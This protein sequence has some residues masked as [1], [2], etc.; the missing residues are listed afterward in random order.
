MSPANPHLHAP[1]G[2]FGASARDASLAV[3]L[4][5][6]RGQSPALMRELV[7]DRFDRPDLAWFAPAADAN[8]WYPERFIAPLEANEP[9][10]LQALERLA[11]LS[12]DLRVWGLPP[13]KQVLV[14]FSQGACLCSEFAW[15]SPNRYAALVAF[16]GALI[17]PP[18]TPRKSPRPAL[19]GLPVLLSTWRDD[20]HVPADSVRESAELFRAA[21][22]QVRLEIG[23]GVEHGIR[24]EEIDFARAL[25]ADGPRDRMSMAG[26]K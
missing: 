15:R 14:G 1:M 2:V 25:L 9:R 12:D 19:A 10:L 22:A 11:R 5:H 8:T 24:A 17:G 18:G 13:S 7:V 16:T 23:P 6:G 26:P 4:V 20:P 21:G 3:I